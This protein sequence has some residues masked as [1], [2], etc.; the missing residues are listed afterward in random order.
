MSHAR[1]IHTEACGGCARQDLPYQ[2]QLQLKHAH[3]KELFSDLVSTELLEDFRVEP[4]PNIW[5]YRNKM[6]FT[7]KPGSTPEELT[8]GLHKLGEYDQLIDLEM[9]HICP[10]VFQNVLQDVRDFAR[11]SGLDAYNSSTFEGFWRFLQVRISNQTG[12]VLV[13]VFTKT[14]ERKTMLELARWLVD[15]NP[16]VRS[17]WWS[18]TP[19]KADAALPETSH[20]LVGAPFILETIAGVDLE[21]SPRTFVQPN[22]PLAGQLYD[23]LKLALDTRPDD[24]LWDLYCGSGSIGLSLATHVSQ[25]FG[26]ERNVDNVA[27]AR[28]AALRNG[29]DNFTVVRGNME[30]IFL[31]RRFKPPQGLE[32][33]E[34]VVTDPPRAGLH[35]RVL[36]NIVKLKPRRWAYI[37][38]RPESLKRDLVQLMALRAPYRPVW[39]RAYDLFPHTKH[40][41]TVIGLERVE[42]QAQ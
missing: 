6:E 31:G 19:G 29:V 16:A 27:G 41:E 9:C 8:L 37:A 34:L 14:D 25:V 12:D 24:V 38:C 17:F 5:H 21:V 20:L 23:D 15:R 18:I 7:F 1:C 33:P 3:L 2:E 36:R 35:Q 32:R 26:I 39:F 40:V 4:S 42:T 30:K 10:E 28:S 22:V 11:R 13:E